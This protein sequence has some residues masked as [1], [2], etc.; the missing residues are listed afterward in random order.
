MEF[1]RPLIVRYKIIN[2]SSHSVVYNIYIFYGYIIFQLVIIKFAL[3]MVVT[4]AA[5]ILSIFPLKAKSHFMFNEA[6]MRSLS[7]AGHEVTIFAPY[8]LT[9]SMPNITLI[10]TDET[11]L[12]PI[13]TALRQSAF[14][15]MLDV[16]PIL[17]SDCEKV[18]MMKEFQ[19]SC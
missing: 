15:F 11:K 12:N 13:K 9:K 7:N 4:D 8:P 3:L 19:V 6:I 17:R 16:F 1:N 18:I 14:Q 5:R 2:S 10:N